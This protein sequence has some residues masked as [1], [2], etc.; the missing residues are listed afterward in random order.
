MYSASLTNI[1]AFDMV[2]INSVSYR[3]EAEGFNIKADTT[4]LYDDLLTTGTISTVNGYSYSPDNFQLKRKVSIDSKQHV[5]TLNYLYAKDYLP[6]SGP[7]RGKFVAM[8]RDSNMISVP[9][10]EYTT[11]IIAGNEYILNGRITSYKV[12]KPFVDTVYTF[13]SRGPLLSSSFQQSTVDGGNNFLFHTTYRPSLSYN[14]FLN[15][16]KPVE[17]LQRGN[18]KHVYLWDYQAQYLAAEVVNADS[19]DVAYTSFE[20]DASGNWTIGSSL[21]DSSTA[22]TGRR[23]YSLS[24][25]SISKAVTIGKTYTLVYWS[26]NGSFTL[27]GASGSAAAG[28]TVQGWTCYTTLLTTTGSTLTISGSGYIDEL[29]LC[30]EGATMKTF[31]YSPLVGITSQCDDKNNLLYYE[32]DGLNRLLRVRDK[33][34]YII[35]QLDYKYEAAIRYYSVAK[36]VT[37]TR[38]VCGV[39]ATPG[40]ATY[41]IAAG[42]YTSV[43]SQADADQQALDAANAGAQEYANTNGSCTWYSISKSGTYTR[44]NCGSGYTGGSYTYTVAAGTYS[45]T[46]DQTTADG[47]AQTDVDNNGQNAANTYGSCTPVSACSPA[48]NTPQR[49]CISG[50]CRRGIQVFTGCSYYGVNQYVYTFH[51]EYPDGTWSGTLQ[52]ITSTPCN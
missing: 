41:T 2:G 35:K 24:N 44:N 51:Y 20:A 47:L 21:R 7:G 19:V 52:Q 28:V 14:R 49:K 48:C 50:V 29:R 25:G 13:E 32:Y 11:S 9:V 43:I 1:G 16:G 17:L 26:K 6:G 27:S 38:Q 10:E 22:L 34:N 18:L 8:L 15:S 39:G 30:P 12:G 3:Q 40:D 36:S 31:T 37:K 33:D 46:V 42:S 45:S 23:C 4:Y 5:S